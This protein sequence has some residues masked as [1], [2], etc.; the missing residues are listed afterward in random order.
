[1]IISPNIVTPI[2]FSSKF[3]FLKTDYDSGIVSLLSLVFE[4][5]KL[6]S[7]ERGNNPDN[8]GVQE[9]CRKNNNR[10]LRRPDKNSTK[11]CN[12]QVDDPAGQRQLP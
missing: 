2:L 10:D 5:R 9:A 6:C 11:N 12:K 4:K 3:S 7:A 1:M 8:S